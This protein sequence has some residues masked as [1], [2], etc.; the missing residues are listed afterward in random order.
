MRTKLTQE[1][2]AKA[3]RLVAEDPTLEP[4]PSGSGYTIARSYAGSSATPGSPTSL[5]ARPGPVAAP[6]A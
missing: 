5:N 1:W 6:A 2:A 4:S 3:E